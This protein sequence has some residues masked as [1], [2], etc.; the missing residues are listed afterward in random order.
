MCNKKS[1][2]R[3]KALTDK[4]LRRCIALMFAGAA[5]QSMNATVFVGDSLLTVNVRQATVR[6]VMSE[7]EQQSDYTFFYYDNAIDVKRKVSLVIKDRPITAVLDALFKGTDNWYT[8]AGKQIYIKR[9]TPNGKNEAQQGDIVGDKRTVKGI[10]TDATDGS[11]LIGAS[12]KIEGTQTGVITDIDGKFSIPNCTSATTL[13]VSYIGYQKRAIPVGDLGFIEAKLSSANEL[14]GV[15]VVGAGTQKKVSVTGAITTV[16]GTDLRAPSSSLTNNLAGKLAG[17]VS[18]VNSGEPGSSSEFYIRGVGTFGGRATPLILLD[19][20]EISA[21]DL[22]RLPAESIESFSI[23]KDASATAIYGARGA[24]GVMLVT[25]KSGIENSKARINV[26]VENSFV[27]PVNRVKYADGATWME[28]Y[29]EASM[30]RNPQAQPYYSAEQIKNTREGINPYVFPDVDWYDLMFK[31]MAMNQRANVNVQGGGSKVTYYMSLQ[32]NHDTGLLD[33]PNTNSFKNNLNQWTYI[34][35]NN[36]S[37]KL[38]TSTKVDLRMNAQIGNLKGPNYSTQTLFNYAYQ[39]NP[40]TFPAYYPALEGDTHIRYGN[41]NLSSGR[42]YTNPYAYMSSSFKEQN[43]STLNTSIAFEQLL[44]FLTRGLKLTALVNFKSYSSSEYSRSFTPWY[45]QT[46]TEDWSAADPYDFHIRQIGP[47][48]SDYISQ[49]GLSRSTDNTFY[50]DVR[51]D[52]Q[53][54]FAAHTVGGMLMYMQREFRNDVLPSRNQGLSGRFTYDYSNK[55]LF[56]FNFGYNGTERLAKGERF[57][58]FPAVSVGWVISSEKF[59]KPVESTVNFLKLRASYGLVGSDETGQ[60]AGAAHFLYQNEVYMN[61]GYGFTTGSAGEYGLWGPQIARLAVENAHWERVKK[62]DVGVDLSLF[63]QLNVTFDYFKDRRDRILMRRGSF[64]MIMGYPDSTPWSNV[65]KVDNKGV[66][67]S[68]NWKKAVM[69]DLAFELRGTFTYNINKYVFK[70]EPDYP[71]DWQR[72]TGKPLSHQKGYVAEGLFRDQAEIDSWAD[73][74]YFGNTIMPGDIKYRDI[75]GDGRVN[76]DDQMM[77]SPYGKMP[78]IQYGFGLNVTWRKFDAGVFFNGSA[79]RTILINGIT[80]YCA[81]DTNGEQNLM[82]WIADARWSE[83]NPDP[84]ATYPRLGILESQISS[85]TRAST[86][87]LRNGNFLRF[88]TFEL[89]YSLPYCRI[90]VNGDNLM[91]WSPF[92]LWDPSLSYSSYPLQRTISIG[93]QFNF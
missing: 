80:P 29:N 17:V 69:K 65:G 45:Y 12:V 4:G 24:N 13:K 81:N 50:L 87:W 60:N 58:F 83:A 72:D 15:V 74:S 56:E 55:Y 88:K 51:L 77:I 21:G 25:T 38:T 33:I 48:G 7:I 62:F 22:N 70:D 67:L 43:F 52:Y 41:A 90:F 57:E 89:G 64:P 53:R 14:E 82:Q 34:F 71:Y 73:M 10:V 40:V 31:D 27:Q 59:W 8:I 93:A 61:S 36:I 92:K 11:P 44:D 30:S 91:V 23:L 3:I 66:E 46:V 79:K 78:R 32:A 2:K 85:N 84:N 39:T 35:Q 19:G 75:T 63:N 42:L 68:V 28:L 86:F 5:F 9:K 49:T 18:V 6:Q 54:R 20:V 16:R 26:S 1:N 47:N 76:Q 37:Y